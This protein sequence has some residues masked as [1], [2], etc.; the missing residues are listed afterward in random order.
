MNDYNNHII[1][2]SLP[3]YGILIESRR[4]RLAET[5]SPHSH[6]TPSILFVVY[7]QGTLEFEDKKYDIESDSI[8]IL[9]KNKNHKL[10]DKPRKQ[11]TIFSVYFDLEKTGLNKYIIDYLL[12]SD[13]PFALPLYHSENI[14][15]HLRQMLFEQNT[16]PPG[17]KL[18]IAQ[19]LSLAVL[20]IYRAKLSKGQQNISQN[21]PA[22]K[23]RIKSV[24]DF[25]SQNCHKPYNLADAARLAKVSQRQFTNLCRQLTNESFIKFLNSVRCKKA[26]QLLKQTEMEIAAIA[27]EAGYE[28]LSTFYRAFK[29]IYKTSPKNFKELF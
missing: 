21:K 19:N 8:I 23:E 9:P 12:N 17:Y 5:T 22:S 20:Q 1:E 3:D 24:L 29:K 4:K 13:E 6:S 28:D 15:S 11:M 10:L 2:L 16:K 18:S 27:F 7:G 14:K 26:A 25:I